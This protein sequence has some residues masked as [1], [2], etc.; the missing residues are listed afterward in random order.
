MSENPLSFTSFLF[1]DQ[2]GYVLSYFKNTFCCYFQDGTKIGFSQRTIIRESL[3]E[4][5][6]LL[7][8]LS[9]KQEV[10]P[11]LIH[12]PLLGC[13]DWREGKARS[14]CSIP[15]LTAPPVETGAL[16]TLLCTDKFS[17]AWASPGRLGWYEW[18]TVRKNLW[19]DMRVLKSLQTLKRKSS[20]NMLSLWHQEMKSFEPQFLIEN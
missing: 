19:F 8:I 5:G 10:G 9:D 7:E 18:V 3:N 4:P 6:V 15:L 2:G 17:R 12:F 11:S 20:C 13:W 16:R 1:P 14:D